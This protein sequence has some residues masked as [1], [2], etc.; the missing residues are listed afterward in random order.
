MNA[1]VTI[2]SLKDNEY[3]TL[4]KVVFVFRKNISAESGLAKYILLH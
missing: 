4:N 2:V 3:E 1:E